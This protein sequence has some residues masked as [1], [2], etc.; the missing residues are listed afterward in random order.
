[1]AIA[2]FRD[3]QFG[4]KLESVPGTKETLSVADYGLELS[5]LGSTTGVEAIDNPVFKGSLSASP[6]RIGKRTAG[7][8]IAG[9]LKN[10]GVLNTK[11][12]IDPI[13]QMAR[14]VPNA[15]KSMTVSG[16]AG[17]GTRGIT[18]LTGAPSGAKGLFVKLEGTKLYYVPTSGVFA[19]GDALTSVSGTLA[20]TAGTQDATAA[21]WLYNPSTT[22]ASEKTGTVYVA[23]GGIA[24]SAFGMVANF[25]MELGV[26]SFPKFSST[27]TGVL[28]APV[29]GTAA[30]R[31]SGITYESQIV[32]VVN[33]AVMR[34]NGT[35]APIASKVTMDL[36][37]NLY[38]IPDLNQDSWLRHGCVTA[39]QAAGTMSILALDPAVY[40]AYQALFAGGTAT[41]E[42]TM[43][44]GAGNVIEIFAPEAQYTGISDSDTNGFLGSELTLKLCGVDSELYLW[45]R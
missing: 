45:Y 1:M 35:V 26:D 25:S 21:G 28:D 3:K 27:L 4:V 8:T 14:M 20:A 23:D 33:N 44:T 22:V 31:V 7:F 38:V 40:N 36:G 32:P 42:F 41:L 34:I 10:S 17:T 37:N 2:L 18:V 15:V 39:R 12:K 30:T 9:E 29:W 24:K 16:V 5:E 19:S 43:G 13:L 11:P 6:S